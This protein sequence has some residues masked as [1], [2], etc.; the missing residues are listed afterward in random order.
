MLPATKLSAS[1]ALVTS[2][3]GQHSGVDVILKDRQGYDIARV[4][5][6]KS[7]RKQEKSPGNSR[8]RKTLNFDSNLS[9]N[10]FSKD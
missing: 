6:T 5:L 3:M 10:P 9:T 4:Q 8:V 2:V 7:L 1:L